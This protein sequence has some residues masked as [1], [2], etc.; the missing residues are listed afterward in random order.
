MFCKSKVLFA[1]SALLVSAS[2]ASLF[3]AEE[4]TSLSEK[5]RD[6]LKTFVKEFVDVTPGKGKFPASFMMG[7]ADGPASE[8]PPT[9]ITFGHRFS[10]ARYEMPQN[11]YEAVMGNNP[12]RWTGPR[13]SAEMFDFPTVQKFCQTITRQLREAKLL[14]DDEEIRLPTEAEWEYCCR[15]GTTTR[16]SFG[17]EARKQGDSGKTARLLDEFGWHTGNASGNDPPVGALKPNAWG[18]YDMHGYLWEFVADDWHDSHEG[19]PANGTARRAKDQKSSPVV[20]G[21]SWMETYDL[22]SSS[23]R[24]TVPANF[25]RADLGF[26]CVRA[27]VRK[28]AKR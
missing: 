11:L 25:K 13:N 2:S 22:L 12:S 26:R 8:R 9:K 23:A 10:I 15:A 16:F 20:R 18:L 21:G 17:D 28:Q 19:A 6:L 5:Q 14:A 27:K 3:A 1:L 7:S 4:S 24:R